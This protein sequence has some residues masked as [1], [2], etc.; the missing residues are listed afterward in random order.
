MK[1]VDTGQMEEENTKKNHF[2]RN[3]GMK[4]KINKLQLEIPRNKSSFHYL[5][6]FYFV[7]YK[8]IPTNSWHT[9]E[10]RGFFPFK[11]YVLQ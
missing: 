6:L 7:F 10:K 4:Q 3:N 11:R 8:I 1:E 2:K 5:F 9:T